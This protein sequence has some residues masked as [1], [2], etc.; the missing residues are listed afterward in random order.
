M[1]EVLKVCYIVGWLQDGPGVCEALDLAFVCR[2][3]RVLVG[4]R[5]GRSVWC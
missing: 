4:S 5:V 1:V 3:F 2:I